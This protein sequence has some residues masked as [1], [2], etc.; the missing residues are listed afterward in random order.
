MADPF[1][2]PGRT[3]LL[4]WLLMVSL[5]IN[6]AVMGLALGFLLRDHT[7]RP[8]RGFD[9]TLGP[10]GRALAPEDRTAIR[11]ALK[12]RPDIM[13]PRR[14][15]EADFTALVM[16]LTQDPYDSDALRK[17]LS[18]PVRR[19]AE[20]QTVAATVLANRIDGMTDEARATLVALLTESRL[21]R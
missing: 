20:I 11:D 13:P 16:A 15:R 5:A 21:P 2:P 3:R 7:G 4:R 10:V 14:A 9:M 19:A 8:P 6:L 12:A 1:P 18:A 17:A